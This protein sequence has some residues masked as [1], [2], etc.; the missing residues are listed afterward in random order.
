MTTCPGRD[1]WETYAELEK[2]V[3]DTAREKQ[4]GLSDVAADFRKAG[5]PDEAMKQQYWAWDK[6]HLGAK[7]KEIAKEAVLKALESQP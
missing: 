3:K 4:T 7:G 6:V 1:R 5:T 2:A